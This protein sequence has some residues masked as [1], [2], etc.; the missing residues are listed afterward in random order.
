MEIITFHCLK[1]WQKSFPKLLVEV[2][3]NEKSTFEELFLKK[4]QKSKLYYSFDT[5][6]NLKTFCTIL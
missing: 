1:F 5:R 3:K 2:T 6:F 4:S